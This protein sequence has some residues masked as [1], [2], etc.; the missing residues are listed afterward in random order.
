MMRERRGVRRAHGG[1]TERIA[2]REIAAG[3]CLA[4][5]LFLLLLN[6]ARV[7]PWLTNGAKI[8]FFKVL[9]ATFPY[10]I[11]TDLVCRT[12]LA[13]RVGYLAGRPFARLFRMSPVC[14]TAVLLGVLSGFPL[15]AKCAAELYKEGTCSKEEAERLIAFTNFCGPPFILSAVGQG[16]FGS[17][18]LGWLIFGV[19]TA[20]SLFFGFFYRRPRE[21]RARPSCGETSAPASLSALFGGAVGD[22]CLQTLR[23]FGCVLFFSIPVGALNALLARTPLPRG[24]PALFAGLLEIS[25]GVAAII[26][27]DFPALAAAC[28]V[29]GFSGLSVM[30]QV[31]SLLSDAGLSMRGYLAAHLICPP[32]T[33]ALC[34]VL[35]KVFGM[36]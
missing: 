33:A 14:F 36:I 15:G 25:S 26:G 10:L 22:A 2:V 16:I 7:G 13:R 9:P 30:M 27:K 23:I 3:V 6:A 21:Y 29:V 32:A 5:L 11:L 12:G 8:A 19:Q 24:L 17:V 31:R 1:V 4:A 28:L 35:A 34:C 20:I 18:A